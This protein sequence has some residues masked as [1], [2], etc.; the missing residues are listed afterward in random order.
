[1]LT[2]MVKLITSSQAKFLQIKMAI[3]KLKTENFIKRTMKIQVN[4]M[5]SVLLI[6]MARLKQMIKFMF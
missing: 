5:K 3:T 4:L 2:K 1:M 6:K